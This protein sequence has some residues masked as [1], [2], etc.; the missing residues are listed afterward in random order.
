M[1]WSIYVSQRPRN[2]HKTK[3]SS[4]GWQRVARETPPHQPNKAHKS[5]AM[6]PCST[7]TFT[8]I[9]TYTYIGIRKSIDWHLIKQ[10]QLHTRKPQSLL[11]LTMISR[12]T[13]TG[14][15]TLLIWV[16]RTSWAAWR[17]KA[18]P[19]DYRWKFDAYRKSGKPIPSN[20]MQ[21]G[22]HLH[23]ANSKNRRQTR[24][25]CDGL[26]LKYVYVSIYDLA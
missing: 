4:N 7:H 20:W 1:P 6:M 22:R 11:M 16:D 10:R 18:L 25:Q 13:V 26:L 23:G 8:Y 17:Q 5:K 12:E 21:A 14:L 2:R 9:Y 19:V 3:M 24:D 15:E